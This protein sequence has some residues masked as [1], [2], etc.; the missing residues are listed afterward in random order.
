MHGPVAIYHQLQGH[1]HNLEIERQREE[2][3]RHHQQDYMRF[4]LPGQMHPQQ[5]NQQQPQQMQPWQRPPGSMNQF[6]SSGGSQPPFPLTP[7]RMQQPM[8][9]NS[10]PLAAMTNMSMGS[11]DAQ[12]HFQASQPQDFFQDSSSSSAVS[13]PTSAGP[14]QSPFTPTGISR[15]RGRGGKRANMG[16]RTPSMEAGM[17]GSPLMDMQKGRL[18]AGN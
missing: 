8:G 14:L 12:G 2:A 7:Q 15:R 17:V 10:N 13:T 18:I 5:A 6:N 4:M 11:Y 1:R 9:L 3:Q 16:D